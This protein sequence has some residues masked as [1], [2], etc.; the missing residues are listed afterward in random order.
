MSLKLFAEHDRL[1]LAVEEVA[2]N[3]ERV[4]LQNGQIS[5]YEQEIRLLRKQ[6]E[7]LENEKEKNQ[8][9]IAELQEAL[10]RVREV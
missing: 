6:L 8:K 10:T 5:A 7:R 1:A 3:R 9:M 2:T 4:V